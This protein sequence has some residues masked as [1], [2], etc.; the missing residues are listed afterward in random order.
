MEL[1]SAPPGRRKACSCRSTCGSTWEVG[2]FYRSL[3][4]PLP[5]PAVL[6]VVPY[7]FPIADA[8][9]DYHLPFKF[10]ALGFSLYRGGA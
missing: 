6:E 8:S 10:T 9:Q 3:G 5:S 2:E 7:R 4:A 1:N